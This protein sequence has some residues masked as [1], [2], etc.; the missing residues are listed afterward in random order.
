MFHYVYLL[1]LKNHD[2][3]TGFT[4]DL[5]RRLTQHENGGVISTKQCR[6]VKL[7]HY[8]AYLMLADARRRE[9]FLKSSDGKRLLKQQIS[10]L[11]LN[12]KKN[13]AIGGDVP[14]WSN[15]SVSKTDVVARLP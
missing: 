3:Y 12:I 13:C 6:P 5:K 8:E 7:I 4:S 14:E 10:C 11:Y 15:G 9:V 2:I 1:L